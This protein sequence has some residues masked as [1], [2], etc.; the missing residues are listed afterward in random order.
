MNTK[1]PDTLILV[2]LAESEKIQRTDFVLPIGAPFGSIGENLTVVADSPSLVDLTPDSKVFPKQKESIT[3]GDQY[4]F[5][6]LD[7]PKAP[8]TDDTK[9]P[10]Q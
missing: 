7:E 9:F 3:Y 1:F 8:A 4:T 2:R 5:Y 10:G 6:R